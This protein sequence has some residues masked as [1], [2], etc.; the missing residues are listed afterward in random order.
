[1][2]ASVAD[3]WGVE[4]ISAGLSAGDGYCLVRGSK[5]ALR[6]ASSADDRLVPVLGIVVVAPGA[7]VVG[8]VAV[9]VVRV[10]GVPGV[11]APGVVGA[12]VPP[13]PVPDVVGVVVVGNDPGVVGAVV[14]VIVLVTGGSVLVVPGPPLSLTSAAA[15]TPSA[16]VAIT[17]IATIGAFQLVGAARRV[18]AAAPQL[19]HHSC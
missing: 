9:G 11:V 3:G 18:R 1:M 19:R 12:V 17:A 13:G 7:D 16:S 6:S 4:G 5:P 15:S 2:S 14:V 8:L 10:V